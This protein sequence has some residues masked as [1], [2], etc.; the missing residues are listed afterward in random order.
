MNGR[1]Y[2]YETR[3]NS[4]SSRRFKIKKRSLDY[5]KAA[6]V[7]AASAI[8]IRTIINEI[9]YLTDTVSFEPTHGPVLGMM[10]AVYCGVL[11]LLWVKLLQ[12][13]VLKIKQHKKNYQDSND[14]E[15]DQNDKDKVSKAIIASSLALST[16]MLFANFAIEW[17]L[18]YSATMLGAIG[19]FVAE[20]MAKK[21]YDKT[22]EDGRTL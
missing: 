1:D 4:N 6:P 21:K 2:S 12:K 13:N 10:N 3:E 7:V 19:T 18:D 17:N 15:L 11:S 16:V 5:Q 20:K 14:S 8:A 9:Y 22:N